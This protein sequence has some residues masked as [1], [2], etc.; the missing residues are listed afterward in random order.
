MKLAEII[1]YRDIMSYNPTLFDILMVHQCL[2]LV[3][4]CY[5][6]NEEMVQERQSSPSQK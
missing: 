1:V 6:P 2:L 4:N 3:A 5:N